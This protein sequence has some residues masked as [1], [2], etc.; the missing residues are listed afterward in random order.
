MNC[1]ELLRKLTDY[2]EGALP[3]CLCSEIERH[4]RECQPCG[5]L[6]S[7]LEDLARLCR[8]SETPRL[9]EEVRRRIEQRLRDAPGSGER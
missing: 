6:R 4:L 8:A 7:D 1:D 2:S 9:P 5:E 3:G